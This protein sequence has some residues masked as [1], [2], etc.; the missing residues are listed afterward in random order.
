M[1]KVKIGAALLLVLFFSTE[2]FSQTLDQA[3]KFIYYERF[4]SAKDALQKIVAATPGNEEAFYWLGQAMIRPDE[5]T[6]KD[7]ADAKQIYQ[8]R[9]SAAP[10][11]TLIMAGIGHIELLEGKFQ[12]ARNHF[13]AA[14]SLS[15]GKNIAVLNA[16]GYANGNPDS[17]NGDA[18]YAINKLKQATQIKKFNDPDVLVNLG[19]AYRKNG[20]GGNAHSSYV[21]ALTLDPKYARAN[22]RLGRLYQSQGKN[23]ETLYLDYYNAA[24]NSDPSYAPVYNNLFNYFYETNVTK[25]AEYFEKWQANSDVDNKTCYYKAYLKYAQALFNDAISKADECIAAEGT[26]PYPNLYRLKALAYNKLKDSVAAK[27]YFYEYFNRQTPEKIAVGDYNQYAQI[28]LK[29]PGNEEQ[30]G[31]LTDKAVALDSEDVNKISYLKSMATYYDAQKK[32]KNA[33]DWYKKILGVK[34]N[35]TKTDL[36]NAGYGYF[37]GNDYN[38]SL[39]IFNQYTQ[40]FPDDIFGYYMAGKAAA[41]LDSTGELGSALPFYQKALEIGEKEGADKTKIKPQLLG[42]YQ[43]FVE[44]NYNIKKDQATA[45]SYI[46]K[47]LLLEPNDAQL[48]ANRDLISKNDPKAAP[49]KPA[50]PKQPAKPKP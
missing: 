12:D 4:N 29:F 26:S 28:L 30:A 33:A 43:Y 47:A 2:I 6:A 23:Q 24:I 5:R 20:D 25:S 39:E 42:T 11:S 35:P 48:I 38:A 50:P 49:K 15:E 46:D 45:L 37:R 10:N 34:K 41:A 8:T 40:K 16:I 9:L 17:K 3:K 31:L 21:A 27:N 32:Y 7:L 13:E 14:I 44:Y 18:E 36:Y 1:N 22:Y 19:D